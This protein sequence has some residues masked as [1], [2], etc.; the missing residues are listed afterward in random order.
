MQDVNGLDQVE[1]TDKFDL[2]HTNLS[3][4]KFNKKKE[5]NF[6]EKFGDSGP[7]C[8]SEI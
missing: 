3:I 1:S 2:G 8:E 4:C 7:I 6:L 5:I